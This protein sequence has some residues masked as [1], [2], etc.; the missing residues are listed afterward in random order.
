V[1]TVQRR[2]AP[3]PGRSNVIVSKAPWKT[4]LCP[5]SPGLL[6][7]GSQNNSKLAR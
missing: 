6:R 4:W 3:V 2:S 7:P 1:G 5:R